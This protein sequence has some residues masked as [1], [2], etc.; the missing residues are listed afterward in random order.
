MKRFLSSILIVIAFYFN[1]NAQLPNWDY[2]KW[3]LNNNNNVTDFGSTAKLGL[4]EKIGTGISTVLFNNGYE[5]IST[6]TQ[7]PSLVDTNTSNT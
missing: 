4:P 7:W 1:A 2:I 5:V 3:G 6:V